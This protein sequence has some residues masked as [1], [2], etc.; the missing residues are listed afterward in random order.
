MT[1]KQLVKIIDSRKKQKS[2][3]SYVCQLISKGTDRLVQKIGE[4]AIEVVI[5]G[6]NGNRR[7][8]ISESADL[9]FH[10]LLF[11]SLQKISLND[12]EK[13]LQERNIGR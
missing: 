6:K 7:E 13:E 5:A 1:L 4:E 9:L 3:E 10:L 8:I 2:P 12:I 11:W